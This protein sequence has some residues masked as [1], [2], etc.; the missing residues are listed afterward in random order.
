MSQD[1]INLTTTLFWNVDT[2]ID[3]IEP[4]G[5][6]Y[7]PGAELLKPVLLKLT[8]LAKRHSTKVVSTADFHF[9]ESKELSN[10]PDFQYTF[11]PHCMA[12]TSGAD[13]IPETEPE[14]AL[15]FDWNKIYTEA[16]FADI[17][18]YRNIVIR[19]DAFDVFNGNHYTERILYEISP[20]TVVVYGVTTNVCV[21]DAVIGLT[22]RIK[23]VIVLTDAIKELPNLPLPFKTWENLGVRLVTISDLEKL[24]D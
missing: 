12:G 19:K 24:I 5:K 6:L 18:K 8:Q 2:Q 10:T 13:F 9:Q 17:S 3:F 7:V 16:N 23:E 1:K 15:I 22:K 14:N 11:P 21:N 20:E 4:G